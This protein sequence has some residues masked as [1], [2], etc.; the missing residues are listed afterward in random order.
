MRDPSDPFY[1]PNTLE[2]NS[3]IEALLAEIRMILYTK[4]GE[5]LG[6]YDFGYNLEDNLYLFNLSSSDL[7]NKLVQAIYYYCPD[8]QTYNVDISVQF[9]KGSVRDICLIDILINGQKALG[10]LAK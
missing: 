5:V 7:R 6:S 1:Q 2:V 9:F 10:V 3:D 8:A 4:Q